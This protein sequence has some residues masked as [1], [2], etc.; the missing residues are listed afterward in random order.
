MKWLEKTNK[1]FIWRGQGERDDCWSLREMLLRYG[2]NCLVLPCSW[3][4]RMQNMPVSKYSTQKEVTLPMK[5]KIKLVSAP[6]S[7]FFSPPHYQMS[8]NFQTWRY[9]WWFN[10]VTKGQKVGCFSL[11]PA[12]LQS[13]G[14]R[15]PWT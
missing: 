10:L 13:L 12:P 14:P 11:T 1:T 6:G 5:I 9:L 15:K 8:S 3:L 4:L 7:S 2:H